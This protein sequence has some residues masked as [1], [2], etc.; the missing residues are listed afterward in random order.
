MFRTLRMLM[1][2]LCVSAVAS[3][4]AQAPVRL[5]LATLAPENSP[6][7]TALADMGAAWT[8]ATAGRVVLTIFGGSSVASESAAIAKMNPSVDSLQAATLTVSGLGEIDE[9]F[10]VFG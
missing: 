8:K 3:L 2:A 1:F 9:A 10:N 6:W 7:H 5:K 4:S